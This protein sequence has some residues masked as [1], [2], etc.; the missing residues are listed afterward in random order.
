MRTAEEEEGTPEHDKGRGSH[1]R[2]PGG[3]R[4]RGQGL[5]E[6]IAV[7]ARP[8]LQGH[9]AGVP[10]RPQVPQQAQGAVAAALLLLVLHR[11]VELRYLGRA[12]RD[13]DVIGHGPGDG[14]HDHDDHGD[15]DHER[16]GR[17]QAA[18]PFRPGAPSAEGCGRSDARA[19]GGGRRGGRPGCA[20]QRSGRSAALGKMPQCSRPRAAAKH[21]GTGLTLASRRGRSLGCVR[22]SGGGE[23]RGTM[24]GPRGSG[25]L[26]SRGARNAG[27][28]ATVGTGWAPALEGTR[29]L[30]STAEAL[31]SLAELCRALPALKRAW[32]EPS[33]GPAELCRALPEYCRALPSPAELY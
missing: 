27:R 7:P 8:H 25:G 23:P 13:V 32:P 19:G 4:C 26:G 14:G 28:S 2:E 17:R 16:G 21:A 15:G 30:P 24:G 9:L 18:G 33:R 31:T 12:G 29:M 6:G 22:R 3:R 10:V 1:P 5:R 11:H 20:V